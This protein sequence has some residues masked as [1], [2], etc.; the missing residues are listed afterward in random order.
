MV[1]NAGCEFDI[2]TNFIMTLE[3]TCATYTLDVKVG[4][5]SAN[6]IFQR[7]KWLNRR[8]YPAPRTLHA[9]VKYVDRDCNRFASVDKI[10][11]VSFDLYC[12]ATWI[13]EA[14]LIVT[15]FV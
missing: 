12:I 15:I 6:D 9:R 8:L 3:T 13:V 2:A 10:F 4:S 14:C 5:F 11:S 1:G 7:A